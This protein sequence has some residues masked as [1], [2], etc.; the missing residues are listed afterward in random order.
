MMNLKPDAPRSRKKGEKGHRSRASPKQKSKQFSF[1]IPADSIP[2]KVIADVRAFVQEKINSLQSLDKK[3][4]FLTNFPYLIC[5][6]FTDKYLHGST[7]S[8]REQPG[9]IS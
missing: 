2:G 1:S 8:V 6:Y 3:K 4:L 5:G 9:G 7:G